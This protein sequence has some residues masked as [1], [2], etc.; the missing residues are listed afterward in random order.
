M[1]D[2]DGFIADLVDARRESDPRRA[3][4][5]VLE[6]T[7]SSPGQVADALP[8]PRG[9]LERLH[10]SPDL[11]VL[12]AAWPPGFGVPPH[13]HRVWAVIGVYAGQEDN[14]FFRRTHTGV[15][16]SGGRALA[17]GDVLSLGADAVHAVVN[18]LRSV[19]AAI[20]V[21]GGDFFTQPRSQFDPDTLE[22][23]PYDG[24]AI[25]AA[26]AAADAAAFADDRD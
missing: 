7:M 15:V 24:D 9:G 5:E 13:D 19:T 12:K 26:F 20:H 14:S 17:T 1:F 10:V 11:T 21:Y 18:P 22:E 8:A 6:R 16:T 25:L 2:T 23:S 3:V 4:R